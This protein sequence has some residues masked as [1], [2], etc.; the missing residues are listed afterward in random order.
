MSESGTIITGKWIN[1]ST[2]LIINVRDTVIDENNNMVVITDKGSIGM[3]EF[4]SQF[5]QCDDETM[6]NLTENN[7]PSNI[8]NINT[9]EQFIQNNVSNNSNNTNYLIIDKM[10][11]KLETKPTINIDIKW[12]ELSNQIQIL[13]DIFDISK[14]EISKY[15]HDNYLNE[16]SI[17]IALDNFIN[18]YISEN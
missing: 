5:I 13:M 16:Y 1:P 18:K 12:D 15:I 6:Q 17:L 14:N 3:N 9:Q 7:I 10:F 8:D 4:S 11:K 2:G